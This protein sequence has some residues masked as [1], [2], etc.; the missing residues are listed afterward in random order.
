MYL[1]CKP[2]KIQIYQNIYRKTA[3]TIKKELGC[4]ALINGG[5]YDMSTFKPVCWLKVD[6]LNIHTETWSDFGFCWNGTQMTIDVTSNINSYQNFISCVTMIKD[7][8]TQPM[9]YNADLGGKRGRTAIGYTSAGNVIMFCTK[10]GTTEAMTPEQLQL[11]MKKLGA[12]G[13]LMLDGGGSSQCVFPDGSIYSARNVQNYIAVW[14]DTSNHTS[15]AQKPSMTTPV[16]TNPTTTNP[17]QGSDA[18]MIVKKYIDVSQFQGNIDFAKLKGNVDGVIIRA[19]YGKNNIDSKF[20]RNV[21][22]CNRLGIPCGAYWFSYAYT[23]AMAEA[24]A[25][26]LVAAVK[27]YKM[28]LPLAF[29]YEYDSTSYGQKQ[30]VSIT[31]TLVKNMTNAFCKAVENAGYYCMLYANPDYIN[32]YFGEL[33]NRYDLWLAQWPNTVD[34]NKPPRTCG[35]WQWGTSTIPGIVGAVDS[36]YAYKDYLVYCKGQW[37]NTSTSSGSSSSGSSSSSSSGSSGSITT[38]TTPTTPTIP[39]TPTTPTVSQPWYTDIMKW[40]KDNGINDGSRATETAT[41]A[42][43][44]QMFY[45]YFNKFGKK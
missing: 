15:N 8:Q 20:I 28:E 32:R 45:N 40:A 2:S 36:N 38:P 37:S 42:E 5:L 22:E 25:K 34:P 29:D 31:A 35:I 3:A 14:I 9:Y 1:I 24:E 44:T 11:E 30:G 16:T 6:G 23:A 12:Q 10:D 43:V 13:A 21:T 18:S 26:Y 17:Q 19:G 33:A 27:P 41:R 39:T 4:D 7:G